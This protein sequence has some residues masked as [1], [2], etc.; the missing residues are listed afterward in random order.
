MY[1]TTA[2]RNG[3]IIGGQE[4]DSIETAARLTSRESGLSLFTHL[5]EMKVLGYSVTKDGTVNAWND[6]LQN[7]IDSKSTL[8][9]PDSLAKIIE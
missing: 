6:D 3:E 2:N 5:Q 9:S 4:V 1:M 7:P 8:L